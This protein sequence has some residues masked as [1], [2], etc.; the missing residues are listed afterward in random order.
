[1]KE[2]EFRLVKCPFCGE[3][4][5]FD[6]GEQLPKCPQCGK[7]L[8]LRTTN[9]SLHRMTIR[10]RY[11]RRCFI[12]TAAYGSPFASDIDVLRAF[13]DQVLERTTFGRFWIKIYYV[14]SPPIAFVIS[15]S[16]YLKIIVRRVLIK[17]LVAKIRTNLR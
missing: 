2:G 15:K 13:R 17:P 8:Q 6:F 7:L 9:D 12:A 5:I 11:K 16:T 14:L 4:F 3:R 1:M 10:S